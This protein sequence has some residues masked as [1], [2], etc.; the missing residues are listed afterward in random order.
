MLASLILVDYGCGVADGSGVGAL[1]PSL[2]WCGDFQMARRPDTDS[3]L[4]VARCENDE[5]DALPDVDLAFLVLLDDTASGNG[6][7]APR[8]WRRNFPT[9]FSGFLGSGRREKLQKSGQMRHSVR[10][11]KKRHWDGSR[12]RS[13]R[14]AVARRPTP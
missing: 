8:G 5:V 13:L 12:R 11:R 7:I 2:F 6:V 3:G 4:P 1:G 10:Q 14:F 9:H